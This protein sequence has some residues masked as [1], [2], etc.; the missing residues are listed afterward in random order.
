MG[1]ILCL[2]EIKAFHLFSFSLKV[3]DIMVDA[4]SFQIIGA[5]APR[6]SVKSRLQPPY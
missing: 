3:I 6:P 4:N 2:S 1:V 5:A